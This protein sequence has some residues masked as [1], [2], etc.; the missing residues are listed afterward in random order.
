[1]NSL[2]KLQRTICLILAMVLC[3][4]ANNA[5]TGGQK[6][7]GRT[8][9]AYALGQQSINTGVT[10]KF[11]VAHDDMWFTDD[12]GSLKKETA[13]LFTEQFFFGYGVTNW[14]DVSIDLPLYHDSWKGHDYKVGLGDLTL[15]IKLMHPGLMPNAPF[16]VSYLL[17]TTFPTGKNGNGY[18]QRHNYY[19]SNSYPETSD[20]FTSSGWSINPMFVWTWDMTKFKKPV[21]VILH[22]NAGATAF[23]F[24]DNEDNVTK[25]NSSLIGKFAAEF[26]LK[27]NFNIY[28]DVYG[29]S[30]LSYYTDEVT[31][32]TFIDEGNSDQLLLS[33]GAK[34]KGKTGLYFG[35]GANIA[36]SD[37]DKRTVWAVNE[38]GADFNYTT[39]PAPKFGFDFTLGFNKIGKKSDPDYDFIPTI[40]DSCPYEAE[41]Y[42][43]YQDED[44]CLDKVH[45]A[46]TIIVTETSTDTVVVV[47]KDTVTITT[48]A[49]KILEYGIITLRAINFKAGSADLLPSSDRALDDIVASLKKYPEVKI[50]I[51]GY[52][53][54]VGNE[55]FNK[56]LS[57]KRAI[58]V[59]KYLVNKGISKKRLRPVGMGEAD[60]IADNKTVEGRVINRRVELKRID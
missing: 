46:D 12:N 14:M 13:F 47:E 59:G 11:D 3:V 45:S 37:K 30:R 24:N 56:Q 33:L 51:R 15:G 27:E 36:L 23:V 32:Q 49:K 60:P 55:E 35:W 42:D 43:E 20:A 40:D 8:I 54:N 10:I 48:E 57:R 58:A 7:I 34:Y 25:D 21:P 18:F 17:N 29:E 2:T 50:E 19:T 28:L 39:S 53:D 31:F 4:F 26:L 41:D 9:S 5:N 6:G 44:G 16:R 52:T 38:N 22:M 1:M